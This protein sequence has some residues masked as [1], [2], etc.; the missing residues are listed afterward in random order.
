MAEVVTVLTVGPTVAG[1]EVT[2]K[3][4]RSLSCCTVEDDVVVVTEI[5]DVTAA[6]VSKVLV[7]PPSPLPEIKLKIP[8][9]LWQKKITENK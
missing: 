2:A 5:G 7:V 4:G 1:V 6:L 3:V 8:F 9:I